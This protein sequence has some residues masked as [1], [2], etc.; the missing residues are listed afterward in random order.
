VDDARPRPDDEL[1]LQLLLEPGREVAVG[2]EDDRVGDLA[3]D[4]LGRGGRD[5]DVG[6]RLHGRRAVDV[7]GDGVA[8]VLPEPLGEEGRRAA[9]G[10]RAAGL[11]V[12]DD[13]RLLRG[14][15]LRRLGHEVDAAERDDPL[16]GG[17]ALARQLER[18]A[19]EVGQ[20]LD[21][22][23]LVVV[24]Q[25]EGVPLLLQAEDRL[26][27]V[28]RRGRRD[29][30]EGRRAHRGDSTARAGSGFSVCYHRSSARKRP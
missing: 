8:R 23:L 30:S 26:G 18:V 11:E 21:L 6:E 7:G 9:V 12:G 16:R 29:G 1:P 20:V 2:G 25:D 27:E 14:Q 28:G 19:D 24:G 15:D 3:Q 17:Q 22:G 10:E 5:D 13:D 4:R